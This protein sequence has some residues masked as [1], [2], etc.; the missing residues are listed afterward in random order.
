M[1]GGGKVSESSPGQVIFR[2]SPLRLGFSLPNTVRGLSG[3]I[4]V[5]S[6]A[7]LIFFLVYAVSL[8]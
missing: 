2:D 4:P 8:A 7:F 6:K 5:D 3:W 1:I